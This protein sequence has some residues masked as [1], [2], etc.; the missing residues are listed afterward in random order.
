MYILKCSCQIFCSSL[1]L[2]QS[3]TL[4]KEENDKRIKAILEEERP[5]IS[6]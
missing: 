1:Q 4:Q 5:K 2:K 3:V 6:K